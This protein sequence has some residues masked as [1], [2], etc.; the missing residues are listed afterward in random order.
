MNALVLTLALLTPLVTVACLHT[1]EPRG[2]VR[3]EVL[4]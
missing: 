4:N 2:D 3:P 1:C